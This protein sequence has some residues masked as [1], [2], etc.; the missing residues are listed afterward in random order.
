M[1]TSGS[2]G[3]SGGRDAKDLRDSISAWLDDTAEG[4]PDA[5][6]SDGI[7]EPEADPLSGHEPTAD[8]PAI[9]IGPAVRLILRNSGGGHGDGPGGSGGGSAGGSG[10]G[11]SSGGA[12]RSIGRISSAAGRAG[13]LAIAYSAG[14]RTPLEEAGLNYDDL[15]ALGDPVSVG[16][17]IVE[18]AF[19]TQ[20]DGTIEDAEARDIVA[21]VVEWILSAPQGQAPSP[22]EV[23]RK[24]IETMIAEVTLTEVGA[25]IR[26]NGASFED[27]RAAENMVRDVAEEYASQITLSSIGASARDIAEAINDGVRDLGRIFGVTS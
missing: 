3:G 17:K 15:R 26:S 8:R 7:G 11:R 23:V 10:S 5:V 27:R 21:V 24:T 25:K 20:A 14:E 13:R 18:A 22:E 4:T 2:F 9:D 16:I 19:D 12:T 6:D 1:G